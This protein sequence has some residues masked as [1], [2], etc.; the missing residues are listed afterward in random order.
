[1]SFNEKFQV[2]E[3]YGESRQKS[4]NLFVDPLKIAT[5]LLKDYAGVRSQV[6]VTELAGLIKGLLQKGE[7]L[8]DKKG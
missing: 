2:G 5:D 7:P 6:S 1:M 3:A 8:D 4:T